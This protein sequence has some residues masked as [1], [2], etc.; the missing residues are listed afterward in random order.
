MRLTSRLFG[1]MLLSVG[2]AAFL[3]LLSIVAVA[4]PFAYRTV[5][6][7]AFR[8]AA[9][10][11]DGYADKVASRFEALA[12]SVRTLAFAFSAFE[13]IPPE[14]RRG[15][16]A[17]EL[18][19]AFEHQPDVL[20]AWAQWE[21]GAIGD[22][23]AP[24]RGT[25]L[26]TESGAFDAT[27]YRANGSI[28]EGG[29]D[30]ATY[31]GDFYTIPKASGRLTLI[32]PYEYSYTGQASDQVLETS[33]CRPISSGGVFRGVV[34]FDFPV[35]LFDGIVS[36]VHPFQTGYGVIVT[37]AGTIV[38]HPRGALVGTAFGGGTPASRRASLLASLR[39]GKSFEFE[40]AGPAKSG[41]SLVFFSPIEIS[42]IASPWYF[43]LVAPKARILVPAQSFALA[44]AGLFLL[45]LA[46]IAA[47]IFATARFLSRPWPRARGAPPPETCPCEPRSRRAGKSASWRS[48]S[49][50]WRPA[51]KARSPAWRPGWPSGP[52]RSRPPTSSSSALSGT[53]DSP[54]TAWRSRPRWP[55][56][57]G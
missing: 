34:G 24:Y 17:A 56:S 25:M 42:G 39:S 1:R 53:C 3:P 55:S 29:I 23:P 7:D 36:S 5:S 10:L 15:V 52:P 35:S 21:P 48:P 57:E 50:A 12:G 54:R 20:A 43:G 8:Y 28:L 16:I 51:S 37:D 46:A 41:D 47:A 6:G 14:R 38:G 31:R 32:A 27:W 40:L 44:L 45:G 2:L 9:T 4:L 19:S 33:L 26:S 18:R 22:D 30:D 13:S 49:T 11:S